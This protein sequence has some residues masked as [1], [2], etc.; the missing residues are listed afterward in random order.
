MP[1]G[2]LRGADDVDCL[3]DPVVGVAPRY[4]GVRRGL[5][6]DDLGKCLAGSHAEEPVKLAVDWPPRELI[7]DFLEC[8]RRLRGMR[9]G[10]WCPDDAWPCGKAV[11][12]LASAAERGASLG[13]HLDPCPLV[14]NICPP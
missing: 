7:D 9:E 11:P 4:G 6:V 1:H 14:T 3:V 2:Q 12:R 13:N 8:L 10:Y 5:D